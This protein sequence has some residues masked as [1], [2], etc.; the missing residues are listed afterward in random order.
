[1]ALGIVLGVGASILAVLVIAFL[2][3]KPA[4][5]Q[6][7]TSASQSSLATASAAAATPTAAPTA[8]GVAMGTVVPTKQGDSF[9]VI[10][11]RRVTSNNQF[12]TPPPGG[13]FSVPGAAATPARLQPA[14]SDFYWQLS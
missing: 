3:N 4:P 10:A 14:N 7:A 13:Y 9:Q 12:N 11:F 1:M 5:S 2:Y 8:Q 6:A